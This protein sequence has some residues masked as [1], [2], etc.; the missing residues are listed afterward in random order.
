[1]P[2]M[3]ILTSG[4]QHALEAPPQLNAAQRKHAFDLPLAVQMEASSLRDRGH[5]IAFY[6]NAGYFRHS[7]R[8]FA[9][10]DFAPR[11]VAYVAAKLGYDPSAF[12]P[13][14]YSQRTLYR[15]RRSIEELC[16]FRSWVKGD[17][18]KLDERISAAV[19][20]HERTKAIFYDCLAWLSN[21]K[22]AVP[23]YR[24]IQDLILASIARNRARQAA[25]IDTHLSDS[26]RAELDALMVVT[27]TTAGDRRF[28]LTALKRHSQSVK[29][30]AVK[31]RLANHAQLSAL[32]HKVEPIIAVLG[33]EEASL[34]A[35][36]AAVIKYDLHDLRRRK[37][38]DRYLHLIAFVAFQFYTLQDNLVATLLTSVKAAQ[39]TAS[40]EHKDWCYSERKSQAAKLQARIEAF[41]SHF[42]GAMAQLQAVF[43]S[44]ALTDTEKLESLQLMLFPIDTPPIL[45]NA[46]LKGMKE[47][48]SISDRDDAQYF[49]ILESRSRALQNRVSGLLKSLIFNAESN[50]KPLFSAIKNF[51]KTQG[52]IA[53]SAPIAFLIPAERAAV[54]EGTNFRPSLYKILLFQ[55]VSEAIKSGSVNLPQSQKYRALD[56]YMIEAEDWKRNR[57]AL[58]KQADMEQ[59]DDPKVVLSQLRLA[60]DQQF[61]HT[62]ENIK[63]GKN[64][65]VRRL[66][67]GKVRVV[68]P[69]Q[70]EVDAPAMMEYL[71]RRHFVPLTEVLGTVNAATSFG[72]NLAHLKPQYGRQ[73]SRAILF[74]GIIGLGC[75]I[76]LRK[77][78]RIS[79]TIS[80]DA[81]DNAATWHL[82]YDNLLAAND[83]ILAFT[84]GLDL[85]EIYRL[86]EGVTHTASDGQ[87]F[88]VA[89]D[90]LGASHSFK[91]FG[92]KQG[93]SIYTFTDAKG[94][95]WYSTGFSAS[96]RESG[97]VID[98]LMHNDV[99]KSDV[100][101][102]DTHGFSEAIFCVTHLLG[103]AFAPRIKNLKRQTLYSFRSGVA[104]KAKIQT[105]KDG[106]L[107]A[108]KYIDEAIVL[109]H[110]EDILRLVVTIKL[111][112]T[113]ASDVFR[114]LNSYSKQNSLYTAMKAFGRITKTLFIL[115]YIDEVD[116]RMSI[117]GML[118]KIELANRFTRAIAIGSPREFASGIPEE[119]KIAEACNR[120][121]K[122][123][124]ICWN[125]M[126][127]EMRLNR[128]DISQKATLLEAIKAHSPMSW[129]H[130]NLLGEYDFSDEKLADSFGI[131]PPNL[132]A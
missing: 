110:W 55:H 20:G 74:A 61:T 52:N 3:R 72:E 104:G 38:A 24:T 92:S 129:A 84:N 11:D 80:E 108:S 118:N 107:Q 96:E 69:K 67:S 54:G 46:L 6:I 119:Q 62:N 58:L 32:F 99:V 94:L 23:S 13:A 59:F 43:K 28:Q 120:L 121:I 53:K 126:Y 31:A 29:P 45:S 116:L 86:N 81:L 114:R 56:G 35:Y 79:R 115:R 131:L 5:Q 2:R 18:A 51:Q 21:E 9:P 14:D 91:Y 26:L 112:R 89:E 68:T 50:S 98:G 93:I 113:T 10:S 71:P 83:Q 49:T 90:S 78:A 39:N 66:A 130:I 128:S 95:L 82:S 125:Y 48:V 109:T 25:L 17:A 100:H 27:E 22:V 37:A 57:S 101:S 19:L 70:D 16:G 122:N 42:Q 63:E 73:T 41:E 124:I 97:Y 132:K 103:I 105:A 47:D 127:L 123:A 30:T 8:C 75:G 106:A 117:E 40:R 12:N 77:M 88:E 60:L 34:Q 4:E 33:W 102:T 1:M 64:L 76:G 65:H 44:G 85:P 111:K 7:R 87:K 15:H 36:A